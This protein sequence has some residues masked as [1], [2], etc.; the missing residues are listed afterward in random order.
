MAHEAFEQKVHQLVDL[1]Q[2]DMDGFLT[3]FSPIHVTWHAR[4]GAVVGGALLPI[5]F[6]TF[7]HTAVVAYKRMLRSINQRMP[8]PFAPGYNS[9]IE[10]VGDPA[11]FSRQV[12]DWHNSVHNSD[13]R[14]MNPATK[15]F[16]PRF[17]GLH[18][19]IDRNFVRW[20]RVHRKITSSE[21]RTV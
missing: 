19:F 2:G 13:M 16:R 6:L 5:G 12:E 8:P 17:W 14:L 15:I 20:Q 11:R 21:H 10:G 18:G 3:A 4:R 9:A 1:F 7:H